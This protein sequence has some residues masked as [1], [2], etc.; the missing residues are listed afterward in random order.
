MPPPRIIHLDLDAFFA[1]VEQR[2]DPTLAGRPVAVAGPGPR[3]VIAAASYEARSRGVRSATP[4]GMARRACPDLVVRP[5]RFAAYE[6]ASS[7]VFAIL[8]RHTDLVEPVSL[9]EAFLDVTHHP[10]DWRVLATG[11]RLEVQREVGLVCSVGGGRTKTVAKLASAAAKPDGMLLISPP[12]EEPFLADLPVGNLW[13]VGPK[14]EA[15]LVELGVS[16]I[17]ELAAADPSLLATHLGANKADTLFRLARNDDPRPVVT[18][19]GAKSIGNRQTLPRDV[20]EQEVAAA[21]L[22][23]L[24]RKVA[25]RAQAAAVSG[26]TVEVQLRDTRFRTRSRQRTFPDGVAAGGTLAGRACT[27]LGELWDGHPVRMV[28]VSISSLGPVSPAT[29]TTPEPEQVPSAYR[30]WQPGDVLDHPLFGEG[31]VT[32]V[33][34]ELVR[35]RFAGRPAEV[36]LPRQS[37]QIASGPSLHG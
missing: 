37:E 19:V 26:R 15:A 9:D 1:S 24:S 18:G 14:A 30:V 33:S 29:L 12:D 36:S 32:A 6:A 31:V 35:L 3:G 10:A 20:A 21:V 22:C 13:G 2:D 23:A 11:L 8:R 4:V 25:R 7:Q 27:L 16:T 5:P 17:G 28:G 34:E